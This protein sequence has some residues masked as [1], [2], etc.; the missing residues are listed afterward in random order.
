MLAIRLLLITLLSTLPAWSLAGEGTQ[1]NVLHVVPVTEEP[2]HVVRHRSEGFLIYT[3]WIEPGIWTQ[4]HEHR[5]DLLALIVGDTVA[6][7]ES[8]AGE[9]R[10][11]TAPAGTLVLFPYSDDSAPYVHRV[12]ATGE[13]PFINVGL[14]F[15][16]PPADACRAKLAPWDE[17]HARELASNR[18]GQGYRLTL[19][20]GAVV[21]LPQDGHGLLLAPLAEGKLQLDLESWRAIVGGF[22]F[23]AEARPRQ[24]KNLGP[25]E[26]GLVVFLAC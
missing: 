23:F 14:E 26:L 19:P 15:L 3:N 9:R 8:L 17:P 24:V 4:Y 22:R 6:S 1:E 20:S 18:R 12:G 2:L 5:N 25:S 10:E 21:K 7:S 13:K 16:R 11:Q